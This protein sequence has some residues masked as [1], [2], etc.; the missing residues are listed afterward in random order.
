MLGRAQ[1]TWLKRELAESDA[2]LKFLVSGGQW[3]NSGKSDSWQSFTRE[4]NGLFNFIR[5]NGIEGVVLL[6]G[7][8]RQAALDYVEGFYDA[9]LARIERGVHPSLHK[10]AV[11]NAFGEREILSSMDRHTVMEYARLRGSRRA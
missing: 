11:R 3:T 5:D 9:D 8:I 4:R 2:T 7:D 10:V 6:S 1:L